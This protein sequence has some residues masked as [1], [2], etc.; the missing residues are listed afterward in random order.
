MILYF[1]YSLDI[2]LLLSFQDASDRAVEAER[3]LR[4][5]DKELSDSNQVVASYRASNARLR[6]ENKIL[7]AGARSDSAAAPGP[8]GATPALLSKNV[9]D[10]LLLCGDSSRPSK[11]MQG[12]A[13]KILLKCAKETKAEMKM[14]VEALTETEVEAEM[15]DQGRDSVC[16]KKVRGC[17]AP[18]A[19]F[20]FSRRTR[21]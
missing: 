20:L 4:H 13:A 17:S 8:V 18:A 21:I 1:E 7:I 19:Y 9:F 12:Y 14:G 6:A 15:E 2:P 16:H 11:L 5:R 3:S 10:K